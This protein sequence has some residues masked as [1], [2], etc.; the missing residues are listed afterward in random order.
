[1]KLDDIKQLH[2]KAYNA[3]QDTRQ[4]AADDLLFYHVTQWDD[5]IL[6]QSNLQY[7]GQF[8]VLRKAGRQ[9][10]SDLRANPVQMNF[11]PK[12]ETSMD[13]ADFLDGLYRSDDRRNTSLEAYDTGSQEAVVCG[14]GAW[15]LHTE[16]ESKRDGTKNQIIKRKPLH[17][18]NNN[19]FFDPNAKLLDKSDACYV[20]ILTAY[21]EDGY[22]KLYKELTGEEKLSSNFASPEQSY[23]FPW[24]FENNQRYVCDFY[25]KKL[26][27]DKVIIFRNPFGETASYRESDIERVEEELINT[28]F[29]I[30]DEKKIERW[31]TTKYIVSGEEILDE[32]IIAGEHIPVVPCYGERAFVEGQEY[33]EG[34]TRLAKDPQ[35]LRNFQ[36]SYLADIVSRSPRPKPIFYPEQVM[37]FEDMYNE[38]GADNDYPYL[39]ANRKTQTGEDLP[40]GI[41]GQMPEQAMPQALIAS[42]EL[43]RQAVEDVANP[44]LPQ[45]IA[46]PD[47]SGKAV[48]AL[49]N[50]MDMQSQV[51][52]Q[53]LKH[54]KR[55]DGEIYASMAA[56]V[57]DAPRKVTVVKPDGQSSQVEVMSSIIDDKGNQV[58]LNDLTSSE[59]DVYTDI[60]P[61]YSSVKE[62]TIERL[63]TLIPMLD[64]NDPMRKI[65][66]LKLTEMMGGDNF[67]D[68]RDYATNEL[69]KLG[70]KEPE[71]P[72][73]EQMLAEMQQNQQPDANTIL[74]Q[75]EAKA[76]EMEGQAALQNEQND[77]V[78]NQINMFKAE[79]DRM[80]VE[81]QAKEAGFNIQNT[82]KKTQA[83]GIKDLAELDMKQQKLNIDKFN[84]LK[85]QNAGNSKQEA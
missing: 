16:Y 73:Q 9:I 71:T 64:P 52:Q 27:N 22:K 1:M 60:G 14:I 79:T 75:S 32:S 53:N 26:I 67:N 70:I 55:R 62:E 19:V 15:E 74:A 76:R 3:N 57:Y 11:E 25:H 18:A 23:A 84:S 40:P 36:L 51:Y 33:Y 38:N 4:R 10:I 5:D 81:I 54:A 42:I 69:I 78:T 20:S 47:L 46:D 48:I 30:V 2:D 8:D 35:R 49:Q 28:G 65:V 85:P 41:A 12:S 80:K 77:Q 29:E 24:I 45:N 21:S 39:L 13:D 50:R 6:G 59:F 7:R 68:I 66:M 31:Q 43:S 44:G 82:A 37:G 56:E 34:V 83:D 58:V 63:T 72:E 17:E 61:S